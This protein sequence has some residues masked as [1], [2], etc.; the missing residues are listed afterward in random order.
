[1]KGWYKVPRALFDKD[2]WR[3]PID[4]RLYFWIA[5]NAVFI[6]EGIP[7][8]SVK[9]G[10]GQFLRS[11]R[12]LKEDLQYTQNNQIKEH[13][14]ST[15][16]ASIKRLEKAEVIRTKTTEL[17]TLFT[18]IDLDRTQKCRTHQDGVNI[19]EQNKLGGSIRKT[20]CSTEHL[21]NNNKNDKK[22]ENNS[23]YD[24]LIERYPKKSNRARA[25]ATFNSINPDQSTFELILEAVDFYKQTE[26]WKQD[27]GL[28]I[29]SLDKW[30]NDEGWKTYESTHK[31]KS[32]CPWV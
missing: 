23:L 20:H 16:N 30:L 9:V 15:I 28:F 11:H 27:G 8:G 17:G 14:L 32:D 31:T 25:L 7:Y 1:M 22:E 24:V 21:P 10:R 18:V 5:G 6:D 29:P 26:S 19:N 12:K 13:S 4:A 3:N 2:I